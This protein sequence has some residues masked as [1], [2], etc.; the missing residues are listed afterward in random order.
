MRLV[1]IAAA[2][3]T[4]TACSPVNTATGTIGGAASSAFNTVTGWFGGSN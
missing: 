3:A 4:V 2:L 1:L